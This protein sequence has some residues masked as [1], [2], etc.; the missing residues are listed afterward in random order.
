MSVRTN[1]V[2]DELAILNGAPSFLTLA[3]G[4]Q[5]P[6]RVQLELPD[7]WK[8]SVTSMKR[9]SDGEPHHYEAKDFDELVDSPILCGNPNIYSF[10]V[11]D[12]EHLLVNAGEAGIWDGTIASRDVA[13]IVAEQQEFWGVVPYERYIFFNLIT[14]SRGGL[15]HD[16]STVLMTSRW[17][18]ATGSHTCDG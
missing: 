6:H 9:V 18:F 15:E 1:W 10:N 13:R 11:G 17:N 16:N 8:L 12:R 3:S 7:D 5:R 14:E 4:L 2:D